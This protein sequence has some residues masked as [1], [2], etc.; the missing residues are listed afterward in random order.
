MQPGRLRKEGKGHSRALMYLYCY[1]ILAIAF[2]P[3][4][5]VSYLSF[6]NSDSV[7]F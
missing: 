5:Y 3:Q 7:V 6:R 1:G 2:M 4:I